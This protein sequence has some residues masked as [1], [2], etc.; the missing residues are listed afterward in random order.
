MSSHREVF[1]LTDKEFKDLLSRGEP[2]NIRPEMMGNSP[3]WLIY[4]RERPVRVLM[5]DTKN[6]PAAYKTVAS[7]VKRITDY[8][9]VAVGYQQTKATMAYFRSF[10]K[11]RET[12]DEAVMRKKT[13]LTT[14]ARQEG[15]GIERVK[16]VYTVNAKNDDGRAVIAKF[17]DSSVEELWPSFPDTI[18]GGNGEPIMRKDT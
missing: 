3:R 16:R 12:F 2:V 15:L 9:G 8:R 13:K 17:C 10:R 6:F 4:T 11:M 7:A 14:L 18:W 5:Y 1:P